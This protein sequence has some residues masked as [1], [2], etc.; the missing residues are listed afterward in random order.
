MKHSIRLFFLTFL[1]V[2]VVG[3]L[4]YILKIESNLDLHPPQHISFNKD[5]T[6]SM[7]SLFTN[8]IP[9]KVPHIPRIEPLVVNDQWQ[10]TM[11]YKKEFDIVPHDNKKV[12]LK[13]EGVMHESNV[14]LNEDYIAHHKGGYLPFSIDISNHLKNGKNSLMVKVDNSDNPVIPPGKSLSDLDFNYYGGIY[15][16]V[17]LVIKNNVYISDPI[18]TNKISSGGVL[19][20]FSE[21]SIKSATCSIKIHAINES[22]KEKEIYAEVILRDDVG[23][24][25]R[26][27]S[28][29]SLIKSGHDGEFK[30]SWDLYKPKLWDTRSPHLYSLTTKLYSDGHNVDS[31]TQKVG[32]R[33]IEINGEGFFLNDRKM[34]IRGTNRHQEYP[35][36]GYAI[37][38]EANYRD[39]V[40]IKQA[41]F[42]LV[43]LSH[44]PQDESFLNACDELGL[45]VMNAIPG[46]Q[47]YQE[48]EFEK[49]SYNDI[50]G[51]V[52]RDRNHP[53]VVFWEPSLNESGM[54]EEYM[55]KA[56]E[57]LKE[58][59]PF[60]DI[61]SAGWIDHESYDLYIPARQ[62]SKPP[63]Y[64]TDYNNGGRKIFIAEYGD[65][66]YYAQNAGFN[67]KAFNDLNEEERTSRQLREYGEKRLL[68]QAL[69]FQEAANSNRRGEHTIGHANWVMFDYNRGYSDDLEAS[70]ISDIFR[71]P[72]FTYYFYQSQRP[73]SESFDFNGVTVGGPMVKIANYWNKDSSTEIKIFSN[74]EEVALF[75]NGSLVDKKIPE[76]NS[77]SSH[78]ENPPFIFMV[79]KY[80][81]GELQ[82]RGYIN[83]KEVAI[84]SV[85]TPGKKK[86]LK[87]DVDKSGMRIGYFGD[88]DIIILN[89]KVL[90]S[91]ENLVTNDN[92]TKVHFKVEK[93]S[94]QLIGDNPSISKAGIA[95]I[96]LNVR[97][98]EKPLKISVKNQSLGKY[99]FDVMH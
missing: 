75:L 70:G 37:S 43:R 66:E 84:D 63:N 73:A 12:F 91:A 28:N 14:W 44:Y 40:K 50:R 53:S 99:T 45:L 7:D 98:N 62:H 9:I 4:S 74:C 6:F 97:N 24:S 76:K 56:N 3:L 77:F 48:G 94:A 95:S 36:I 68:Q 21:V 57:I 80:S 22:I 23:K 65:W 15:R 19:V 58:E 32:I 89:A 39:A 51:M 34:Y 25:I 33:K 30:I 90:D 41:G 8:S 83:G 86:E 54:T 55:I 13:F 18:L 29:S 60:L 81:P 17:E 93:G 85:I 47:F 69:N 16:D 35:F 78:L 5:W 1:S 2:L 20:H 11:W 88:N 64:W 10:G 87:L 49:N 82:A 79:P 42:D 26:K 31:M 46:W 92:H 38:N 27:V 96:L 67:Q 72:K 52:R 71:N 61:Y 59:L